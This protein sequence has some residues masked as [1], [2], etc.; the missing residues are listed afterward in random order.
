MNGF[1]SLAVDVT[2]REDVERCISVVGKWRDV[3]N[4]SGWVNRV[5]KWRLVCESL[6]LIDTLR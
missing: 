3:V 5:Q 1:S 2:L 6:G 4:R